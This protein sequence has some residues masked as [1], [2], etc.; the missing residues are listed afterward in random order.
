MIDAWLQ[1]LSSPFPCPWSSLP[2]FLYP[3]PPCCATAE[4]FLSRGFST[5][6][7]Y[8]AFLSRSTDGL[9]KGYRL[10]SDSG[11][12]RR[13]KDTLAN[14]SV[15]NYPALPF[16]RTDATA[17]AA[18]RGGTRWGE[19]ERG[20]GKRESR[21]KRAS[22]RSSAG[23]RVPISPNRNDKSRINYECQGRPWSVTPSR[24]G[25]APF[26]DRLG[27]DIFTLRNRLGEGSRPTIITVVRR[28]KDRSPSRF[29]L[30][31]SRSSLVDFFALALFFS[32][33]NNELRVLCMNI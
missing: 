19:N 27:S 17:T 12:E 2:F 30:Q 8:R 26:T 31:Q 28:F 24:V 7:T 20:Q 29:P 23:N 15:A 22:G 4:T 33:S 11:D 10:G 5:S 18:S 14:K 6:R 16:S 25:T 13:Q 21:E 32:P 3:S 9:R 1:S